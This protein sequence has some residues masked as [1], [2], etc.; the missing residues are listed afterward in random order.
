M[1]GIVSTIEKRFTVFASL[2]LAAL[3]VVLY[4]H[5]LS[6]GFFLD[7]AT[8]IRVEPLMLQPDILPLYEKFKLRF[9]GYLSFWINYQISGEDPAA[10]RI[11]NF[12]I[13]A[14]NGLLVYVLSYRLFALSGDAK[15]EKSTHRWVALLVAALF[16]AHPLQ[17]QAVTYIVQRLASLVT[18]FYLAALISW[19]E[20][21]RARSLGARAIWLALFAGLFLASCYTKQNAFT[22]PI[23]LILMELLIFCRLTA[24]HWSAISVIT[25]I[26]ALGTFVFLPDLS[27]N[28]DRLTRETPDIT[29]WEY[30]THQWVILWMYLG[31]VIWPYPQLLD[32][33]VALHSFD[34]WELILAGLGHLAVFVLVL[35]LSGRLPLLAFGVL[36]FYAVHSVESG[37]I[38]IRDLVFEHRNY[39]PLFGVF[40]SAGAALIASANHYPVFF[41]RA[42]WLSIA[43][44]IFFA[45][46]TWARNQM[47]AEQETLLKQ[48][49]IHNPENVRALYNLALWYQRN[50]RYDQSMETMKVLVKA[51]N[52]Q[53]NLLHATTYVATM[54]DLQLY[55]LALNLLDKLLE[56]SMKPLARAAFLRQY[57]TVLTGKA[58]DEAAADVFEEAMRLAPLDYDSGL[59]YGYSLI[60]LGRLE[61]ANEEINALRMRFGERTRLRML[62]RVLQN[63]AQELSQ[64]TRK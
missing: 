49:V 53:L 1:N 10:F 30:F 45:Q 64:E 58:D 32:Y 4:Q 41:K 62:N 57:A 11:V 26:F 31:K 17:T 46:A 7:D 61:E 2:L 34:T 54:I 25:L 47:W 12:V 27:A 3:T 15:S 40:F 6:S 44:L 63:K 33:G 18:L 29:R 48:D 13:H 55:D 28:V 52:G 22:L 16:I 20:V 5:A 51:N 43:I 21:F 36:F 37:L 14:V 9:L 50:D 56:A 23:V 35:A 19:V 24:K 8:S 60:Q 38:P 42:K 59:A 39:L